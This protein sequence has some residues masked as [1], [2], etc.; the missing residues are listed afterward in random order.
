MKNSFLL[1]TALLLCGCARFGTLQTDE[2]YDPETGKPIRKITTRAASS[3]FFEA[4]STLAKWK[5]TQSDKTQGAEVGGL[6]QS[7][8]ATNL[9]NLMEAVT[10]GAAQGA[11]AAVGGTVFVP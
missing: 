10:R 5:A 8:S 11:A 4:D 3:T 9:V 2:S 1:L 6:G 7:A